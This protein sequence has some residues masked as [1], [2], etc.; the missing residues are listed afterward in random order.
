MVST[1]F[2]APVGEV[3]DGKFRVTKEIGRGGMAT[4][5][6]AE[7]VDIGKLVA[8]KIL[9]ED[10]ATSKTVNERFLREA[11]T[12]AKIQSPYICEVYDVGMYQDR[13]FIVM[14]L[15][16]GESLYDKLAR[17]RQLSIQDTLRISTQTAKGLKKAHEI[18][19]VHRDLKPEN[20]FL[21]QGEDGAPH[22][23]LVDFGLAKFYE[24]HNDAANARL[25]KEGA[26][27]GTPAYMS[28]E[29]AK[30][31]GNV[32]QRS[33]LWALGCIVYEMLTGR[34]VWDVEQGVAMILAQIA[35][36]QI[37]NARELRPDLPAAFDAWLARALSR[38]VE[39]RFQNAD[40]FVRELKLALALGDR[41][42]P[43]SSNT[44]YDPLPAAA[45]LP[46]GGRATPTDPG[47]VPPP[48]GTTV[49]PRNKRRWWYAALAFIAG[50]A[51][52]GWLYLGGGMK[53]IAGSSAPP[54]ESAPLAER[55]A[56]AQELLGN[57]ELDK[58]LSLLRSAFDEG[59]SKAARSLLSHVSVAKDDSTGPCKLDGIAHPRPFDSSTE[60]SKPAI[61]QTDRG[62]LVTWSDG[63]PGGETVHART[64]LLDDTLRRTTLLSDITPEAHTVRDPELLSVGAGLGVLYWDFAG[65][66]S[67]AY[68]RLLDREGKV[69]G[70]PQLL[71]SQVPNHPYYP[72][73]ARDSDGTFWVVWVE[74]SRDRV[75]DLHVRQLNDKLEPI[76]DAVALTGYA[77]PVHGKKQA[78]RPSLSIAGPLLVVTYTLRRSKT[79]QLMMLRVAKDKARAGG[80]IPDSRPSAPGDEESDRFLGQVIQV[81]EQ[82]GR[83]DQSI[84]RCGAAGCFVTWDDAPSASHIAF[85]RTDGTFL[86]RRKLETNAARPALALAGDGTGGMI[87][88][89]QNKKVHLAPLNADAPG[90]PSVVGRV[91][92][93]LQ[94]P[95]P[96]VVAD[97]GTPGRWYVAWR[98]YEAAVPEPFIARVDCNQ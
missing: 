35:S 29:Q 34:T 79:Q 46:L 6:S 45:P 57:G 85:A 92:G 89:Y 14:E 56:E 73:I 91:S 62:L 55:V 66:K 87:A 26:L 76:S 10:L 63:S 54:V 82:A 59:Q 97:Q 74:P 41:G 13:P 42:S 65:A 67:G 39:T 64:T 75:F 25:T 38:K 20:I 5:Y 36:A 93:E 40:E 49:P 72:V 69:A 98:G 61:L 96:L 52:G 24:P 9:A 27:F 18:N 15:L 28:P 95:P 17:E 84:V 3:L 33:D 78:A 1:S 21:T 19:V 77:T 22:T 11:R 81:N 7:N 4:V 53:T 60:S 80:A 88:W 30:G 58:S 2:A 86:W 32:D 48:N 68:T 23:K 51:V 16:D 44:P 71:S 43:T 50:G 94:Q 70:P 8:V 37:P 31:K 12:A 47:S 90:Q 83:H